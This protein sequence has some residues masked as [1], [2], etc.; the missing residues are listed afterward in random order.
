LTAGGGVFTV[1]G[2]RRGRDLLH[3]GNRRG[4]EVNCEQGDP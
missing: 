1:F 4:F 2:P 3:I